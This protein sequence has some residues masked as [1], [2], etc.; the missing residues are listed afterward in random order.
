MSKSEIRST[1]R[2]ASPGESVERRRPGRARTFK[3]PRRVNLIF[4]GEDHARLMRYLGWLQSREG[5][6]TSMGRVLM[7]AL[8]E[9]RL[10]R[11]WERENGGQ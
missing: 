8:R 1:R 6:P 9:S 3:N 11:E 7:T 5:I 4:E 10:F 2:P